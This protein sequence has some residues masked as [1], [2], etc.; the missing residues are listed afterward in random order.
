MLFVGVDVHKATSQV[1]VVSGKGETALRLC[2]NSQLPPAPE[3]STG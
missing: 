1:T 2:W 3:S